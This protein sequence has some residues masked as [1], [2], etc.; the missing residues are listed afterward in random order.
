MK[1]VALAIISILALGSARA[2][3][4]LL[5]NMES[6]G[7]GGPAIGITSIHK[8]TAVLVGGCGGW[9][10][11]HTLTLGGA[12]YGL[13]NEVRSTAS[14][15]DTNQIIDFGYGGG[16][17]AVTFMS[18]NVIHPNVSL[19]I[20]AGG[21][22]YHNNYAHMVSGNFYYD[23]RITRTVFVLEP[24]ANL[25]LNVVHYMRVT[26]G[27]SYRLITGVDLDGFTNAD[28]SGVSGMLTFKFGKF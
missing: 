10:I 24:A 13:V 12:G 14:N 22:G 26:L 25:E 27:V 9:I 28:F 19:F 4:T 2:E 18:D 8:N 11:N 21:I 3:E 20:G 5:S 23:N 6:G 16:L 1:H 17:V 15:A 7:W